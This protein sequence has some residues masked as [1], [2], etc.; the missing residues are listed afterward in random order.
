MHMGSG[1]HARGVTKMY[2]VTESLNRL[3]V[4]VTPP[5]I[6]RPP[7]GSS[8]HFLLRAPQRRRYRGSHPLPMAGINLNDPRYKI[9]FTVGGSAAAK[10]DSLVEDGPL[11]VA[12][13][14]WLVT[15]LPDDCPV[16]AAGHHH[17]SQ[18]LNEHITL[19]AL[20]WDDALW[21]RDLRWSLLPSRLT[22]L[23][24]H[25]D[26]AGTLVWKKFESKEEVVEHLVHVRMA[27]PAPQQIITIADVRAMAVVPMG[28]GITDVT[29]LIKASAFRMGDD[30]ASA[31]VDYKCLLS[32]G[33]VETRRQDPSGVFQMLLAI[34]LDYAGNDLASKPLPVQA[35]RLVQFCRDSQPPTRMSRMYLAWDM[36]ADEM[37]RR[38]LT[39]PSDQ[40]IGLLIRAWD[41]GSDCGF[42]NL[43]KI[44]HLACIGTEF[45]HYVQVLATR[46]RMSQDLTAP[47]CTALHDLLSPEIMDELDSAALKGASNVTRSTA[48]GN[49]LAAAVAAEKSGE[50]KK[51]AKEVTAMQTSAPYKA[52]ISVL[53]AN[54]T[55][56]PDYNAVVKA[57]AETSVGRIFLT[58]GKEAAPIY[59]K[60]KAARGFHELTQALNF[61][62][63]VDEAGVAL[64]GTVVLAGVAVKLISGKF[65]TA[66]L[67]PW[68]EIVKPV[69]ELRDGKTAANKLSQQGDGA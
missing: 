53:E 20:I 65:N 16:T 23:L 7:P 56:A 57:L 62:L 3:S 61:V 31:A 46:A 54:N 2:S 63:A 33:Y 69:I 52:V 35:N 29:V 34:L 1:A 21:N 12:P 42:P 59:A 67:D 6:V 11:V 39:T 37:A 24:A 36:Q 26:A 9:D 51:D 43:A 64:V 47:S 58:N 25:G 41:N 44:F 5:S 45:A 48:V 4:L 50:T 14:H 55:T 22:R 27:L 32:D 68:K 49:L 10:N 40:F 66:S 17:F 13:S 60:F 15:A 8:A 30:R 38:A 28:P 18:H 19:D